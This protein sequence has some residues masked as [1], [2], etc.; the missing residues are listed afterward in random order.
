MRLFGFGRRAPPRAA[1]SLPEGMRAYAVGDVHGRLD[2]LTEL[3]ALIEADD[4]GRAPAETHLVM[5]GDLIDRG[6]ASAG[7]IELLRGTPPSFATLHLIMGNHEEM[8]L[9]MIDAPAAEEMAQFLRYGGYETLAS[10]GA[11]E[12]MLEIPERY[13]PDALTA[14]VPE[15]HRAFLRS[16]ADSVRLGGYLFVHAGIR[17]EVAIERQAPLDLRWIRR[18]F[19]DSDA[20]HGVTV[21]HG[22]TISAKPE[23]RANRIGIDTG[24]YASGVLTALGLEGTAQW[25]ISTGG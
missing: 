7:V 21:V 8:L 13:P 24:A 22:H 9:R 20:D 11:P 12:A 15:E 18:E 5:L 25:L 19:L 23:M 4:R 14:F 6:P 16:L 17:P 10:Y 2:L 3:L 1:A